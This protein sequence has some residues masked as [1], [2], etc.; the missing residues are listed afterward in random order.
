MATKASTIQRTTIANVRGSELPA[1]WAE[2]AGVHP[3]QEIDVVIQDRKAAM[4]RLSKLM[5]ELGSEAE[6]SGL[7]EEGL[8]ALLKEIKD[9][10]R[11]TTTN[12]LSSGWCWIPMLLSAPF[13]SLRVSPG[14]YCKP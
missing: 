5:D 8:D 13:V 12:C 3:D 11:D 7:T 10:R 2:R 4:R 14:K 9:E 6:A 1:A